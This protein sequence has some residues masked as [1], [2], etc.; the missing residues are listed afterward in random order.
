M[1]LLFVAEYLRP[2]VGFGASGFNGIES[3]GIVG[4]WMDF[5]SL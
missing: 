1:S 5:T 4:W 3:T 2:R